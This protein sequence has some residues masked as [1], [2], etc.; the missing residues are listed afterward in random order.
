LEGLEGFGN[1]EEARVA[2]EGGDAAGGA[3]E[4]IE[5]GGDVEEFGA[6]FEEGGVEDVGGAG[7]HG[8]GL[9]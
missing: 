7:V 6:E 3:V 1:E 9:R 4:T 5:G 2:A 8:R